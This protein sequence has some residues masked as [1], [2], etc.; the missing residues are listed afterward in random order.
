MKLLQ[1]IQ[2]DIKDNKIF[3]RVFHNYY[4]LKEKSD[5]LSI[6]NNFTFNR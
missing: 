1:E 2:T 4:S 3:I 5:E 6:L